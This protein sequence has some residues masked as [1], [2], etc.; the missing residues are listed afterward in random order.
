MNCLLLLGMSNTDKIDV[1]RSRFVHQLS[2]KIN[3]FKVIFNYLQIDIFFSFNFPKI[4]DLA[5]LP[6]A[7]SKKNTFL[8]LKA[9]I[10]FIIKFLFIISVYCST[11]V[12]GIKGMITKKIGFM[13]A[14]NI[15]TRRVNKMYG[16][17]YIE[18]HNGAGLEVYLECVKPRKD[19]K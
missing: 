2:I 3:L 9:L 17:Q 5:L 12:M 18:L 8:I 13:F 1:G 6:L 11:Q 15:T 14:Q 16:D 7:N 4:N 19:N 10:V